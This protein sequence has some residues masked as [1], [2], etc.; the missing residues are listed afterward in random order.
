V[1]EMLVNIPWQECITHLASIKFQRPTHAKFKFGQTATALHVVNM[2][3]PHLD[4]QHC[5]MLNQVGKIM[6]TFGKEGG[7]ETR[8][9]FLVLTSTMKAKMKWNLVALFVAYAAYMAF[10]PTKLGGSQ[11]FRIKMFK[12]TMDSILPQNGKVDPNVG[13]FKEDALIIVK[14]SQEHQDFASKKDAD[15]PTP[16]K[17]PF[18][19]FSNRVMHST[20]MH[21]SHWLLASSEYLL[22]RTMRMRQTI[23]VRR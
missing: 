18:R 6:T 23:S 21:C 13:Q 20:L 9:P 14:L 19:V 17:G 15:V 16:A 3:V 11:E 8:Q 1:I 2:V 10:D 22:A 4:R 12:L 7:G 5:P